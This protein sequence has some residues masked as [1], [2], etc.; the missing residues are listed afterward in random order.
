MHLAKF[1]QFHSTS[2]L[3]FTINLNFFLIELQYRN[4]VKQLLV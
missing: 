3:I 2:S 1:I 4:L